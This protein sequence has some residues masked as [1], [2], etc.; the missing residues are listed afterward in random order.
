VVLTSE[1]TGPARANGVRVLRVACKTDIK[2]GVEGV[3]PQSRECRSGLDEGS[4]LIF[5]FAVL[6]MCS[7]CW[8]IAAPGG[9][10][11]ARQVLAEALYLP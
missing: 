2:L 1:T 9:M 5:T 8:L 4:S 7:F 3:V 11:V 10:N 6:N